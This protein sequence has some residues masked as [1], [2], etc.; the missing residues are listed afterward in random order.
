MLENR[1]SDKKKNMYSFN[2]D[3]TAAS[4]LIAYLNPVGDCVDQ[5]RVM[6]FS[7]CE[8]AQEINTGSCSK[9]A[10]PKGTYRYYKYSAGSDQ[11]IFPILNKIKRDYS[12]VKPCVF[13]GKDNQIIDSNTPVSNL[14]TSGN[15]QCSSKTALSIKAG[16][17]KC[18]AVYSA[19]NADY[20]LKVFSSGASS[21]VT[22][23]GTPNST[24]PVWSYASVPYSAAANGNTV[25][26]FGTNSYAG[27]S[28]GFNFSY[29]GQTYSSIYITNNGT[30]SFYTGKIDSTNP[31]NLF[32]YGY[33]NA[34]GADT[35]LSAIAPWW[36]KLY[37]DCSSSV[38]YETSGT[39]PDRVFTAEWKNI[40]YAQEK[41]TPTESPLRLSFQLKLYET[42]NKIE[43]HYG[44]SSGKITSSSSGS[45][46]DLTG[47]I[48]ISSGTAGIFMNGKSGSTKDDNTYDYTGFPV[49]GTVYRFTP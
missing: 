14:E 33:Y 38:T 2:S 45:T 21:T 22:A 18:I 40:K 36:G 12:Y 26:V 9:E 11:N 48:G 32:G 29:F 13:S 47:V 44:Q 46:F 35:L 8:N 28:L 4:F 15:V 20:E 23:S 43:F 49:S 6:S 7:S 10:L 34:S 24:M 5:F 31:N 1:R 39:A 16:S 19:C 27:I 30:A 41:I 42:S 37:A 3:Q 25:P 17:F